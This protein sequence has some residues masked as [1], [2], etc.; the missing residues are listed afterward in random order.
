MPSNGVVSSNCRWKVRSASSAAVTSVIN[1]NES[2][3]LARREHRAA[4]DVLISS[5]LFAGCNIAWRFGSGPAIGIVGF[6]VL[7]GAVV[8]VVVARWQR[9]GSWRDPL[10][11]P[12]GRKAVVIQVV[13][14]VAAGTMF[15]TLDGPLAGLTLACVPAVA[16]LFRD[17]SGA[18]ATIAAVGSSTAAVVGLTF[19]AADGGVAS[20]SFAGA[21]T[22]VVFVGI[23]VWSLRTSELAVEG[24]INPT[25][26]VVSTMVLG[27]IVLLPFG[28][29][30][31]TLQQ[32]WT[33]WGALGAALAVALF[34]TIGRVLRTA[35]LPATGIA[36]VAASAQITALFTALGGVILVNDSVS[37][38]SL[39]CTL[40]AAGMGATAVIAAAHWRLRR[41]PD[42]GLALDS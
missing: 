9:A 20:V 17:R 28:L 5:V 1:S 38:M 41:Q 3:L 33:I 31:G 22:A 26:I 36:A 23:E 19:A 14:L 4:A 30:L 18:L 35:A 34:G 25:T 12:I 6:R 21:L 37:L 11:V 10:K 27:S 7:L 32:P 40:I 16:L 8:A 29:I 2:R 15:R 24:G 42:L 13:G 39:L